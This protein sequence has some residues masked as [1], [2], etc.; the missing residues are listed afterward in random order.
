MLAL[1]QDVQEKVIQELEYVFDSID[2]VTD[3]DML[4]NLPYLEMVIKETMRF[5]PIAAFLG[6][7]ATKDIKLKSCTIPAGANIL[8]NMLKVH[9]N[10]IYW[11]DDAHL[12]NPDRFMPENISKI[13]PYAYLPFSKGIRNC[14]GIKYAMNVMKV[15]LTHILRNY[16]VT[17]SLKLEDLECKMSLTLQVVQGYMIK[18][19]K[20]VFK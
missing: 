4:N 17:T 11:S 2:Q 10:P 7:E 19:E 1:H 8:I 15:I 16:K 14:I 3:N 12:F 20:R 5:F 6:R 9:R 13:H 18:L